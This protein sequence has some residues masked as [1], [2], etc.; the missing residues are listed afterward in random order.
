METDK[1]T[2]E[3]AGQI[4]AAAFRQA[5]IEYLPIADL[6]PYANNART[7]DDRQLDIMAAS[8]REFGFRNPAIVDSTGVIIAGHG[9]IEAARRI[10]MT[11]VPAI[12]IEDL[13]EAQIRA[14]RIAD[15][16]IAELSGWA[17][18]ILAIELEFLTEIEFE[19]VEAIGFSMPEIDIRLDGKAKQDSGEED[20][21]TEEIPPLAGEAISRIGDLWVM[22]GKHR[23]LCGSALDAENYDRL[24]EGREAD[25]ILQDPPWNCKVSSISGSGR[26][27]SREFVMA[28]GEMSDDEFRKFI[29]DELAENA[30][31]AREGAVLLVFIDWR[32][33]EKVIAAGL[34]LG[35]KHIA[36]CIW[37]KGHGS[38]GVPWRSAHEMVVA[39]SKPGAQ[40]KDNVKLGKYGRVRNNVWEVPGMGS[41]GKGR[42]EALKSHPTSKPT[43]LLIEAIRDVTDRGEL[44]IDTFMGSGSLLIAAH[45]CG[46]VACGMELDPLYVDTILRRWEKYTGEPAILEGDGRTF[47]EVTAERLA[48]RSA[49]VRWRVRPARMAE[50]RR[51]IMTS[52]WYRNL[53]PNTRLADRGNRDGTLSTSAGGKIRSVS[54]GGA[55]TGRGADVIILDDCMKADALTSE[56]A[57]EDV[58]NWYSRTLSQRLNDKR[59]GIILSIQQRICEDDL[60][61]FLLEKDFAYLNLPAKA[62]QDLVV[63]TGPGVQHEWK[64]GELLDPE[65]FPESVLEQ[66][67]LNLGPRD[68]SAQYLQNPVSP[69]GNL[70]RMDHFRRYEVDFKREDFDRVVQSWDPAATDLPTSDWSVCTTWGSLAGRF[71]LLGIVRERLAYPDL[72]RRVIA[73][74]AKWGA[75][76]VIIERS[77]N[78]LALVQQLNC[79]GPFRPISWPP[80]GMRQLD[81]AE[82]LIAQTGQIEEG[83]VWLP[84]QMEGLSTFMSE[85]RAFPAGR[86]DDQVDSLTQMLEWSFWRW[87]VLQQERNASGRLKDRV[88]GKRPRLPALPDWIR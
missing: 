54:V 30:R 5:R 63:E 61:A 59:T 85:L 57:R 32:G 29:V 71:F 55:V 70:V 87:R 10:G 66:E 76:H 7:H 73:E 42:M 81:K 74:R 28:S 22:G 53:F 44:V 36:V 79:E 35:L 48:Q 18:D 23:L 12:R 64:R 75:E 27:K 21:A 17:D 78:G 49:P 14:Y 51:T 56:A 39:F 58:K 3:L 9:R 37:F 50:A 46:R 45:K 26:T 83:R 43:T 52:D 20:D 41:F 8:I 34:S 4:E 47:A 80:V 16:R 68:F 24:L 77:S 60:P 11:E 31:H 69:G 2:K 67:R 15:N 88:R 25:L 1:N 72:K 40:I 33:V 65:R 13:S 6:K 38:F 82:R 62:E 86:Y 84:A 19:A